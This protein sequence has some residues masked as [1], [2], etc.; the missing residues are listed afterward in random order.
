MTFGKPSAARVF[1]LPAGPLIQMLYAGRDSLSNDGI[2]LLLQ[3]LHAP[4]M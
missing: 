3:L 2:F 4:F 1:P